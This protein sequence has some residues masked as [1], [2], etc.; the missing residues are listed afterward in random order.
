MMKKWNEQMPHGVTKKRPTKKE[1][2][3]SFGTLSSMIEFRERAH[4]WGGGEKGIRAA[5]AQ[6]Q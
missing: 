3:I 5:E 4:T 6:N 1:K 2:N